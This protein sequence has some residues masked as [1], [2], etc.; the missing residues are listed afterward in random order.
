MGAHDDAYV[1]GIG[2]SHLATASDQLISLD[3]WPVILRQ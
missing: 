3:G 2:L 1:M